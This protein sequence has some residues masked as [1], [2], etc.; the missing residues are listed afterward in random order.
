MQYVYKFQI[1]V[2][3]SWIYLDSLTLDYNV[4]NEKMHIHKKL[5]KK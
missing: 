2:F 1:K 4:R 5:S 3:Y